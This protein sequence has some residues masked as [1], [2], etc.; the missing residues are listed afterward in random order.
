[1]PLLYADGSP[2][3]T[4]QTRADATPSFLCDGC[5]YV[6]PA[7]S[8]HTGNFGS[9]REG[10]TFCPSCCRDR[11]LE[12]MEAEGRISSYLSTD[13]RTIGTWHGLP[14]MRCES[15][16]L[17]RKT[18]WTE[19]YNLRAIDARGRLWVGR[20]GGSGMWCNL[21]LAKVPRTHSVTV[22]VTDLQYDG[23]SL[24]ANGAWRREFTAK[25][26]TRGGAIRKA[27]AQYGTGWRRNAWASNDESWKLSGAMIGAYVEGEG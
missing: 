21:R 3:F 4:S 27:L 2:A 5:A 15:C 13:G 19:V 23:V 10:R 1:M 25:A 17:H 12:S 11:D 18:L 6:G 26:S 8:E 24:C 20:G 16:T 9:D 22:I 7:F 14:L